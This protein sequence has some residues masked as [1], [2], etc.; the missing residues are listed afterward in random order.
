MQRKRM[1]RKRMIIALG[2]ALLS[3]IGAGSVVLGDLR[4]PGRSSDDVTSWVT[5][6]M[7][8]VAAETSQTRQIVVAARDL[9]AGTVLQPLDIK[10]VQRPGD[11]D[12]PTYA[13]DESAVLGRELV[14]HVSADEPLLEATLAQPGQGSGL[15]GVNSEG[16]GADSVKVDAGIDVA[17]SVLPGGSP[18]SCRRRKPGS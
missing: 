11:R 10:V 14:A 12:P 4:M 3:G 5:S 13:S 18:C 16:T 17:G 7:E 15:P 2:L 1:Q 9:P 6:S 8:D